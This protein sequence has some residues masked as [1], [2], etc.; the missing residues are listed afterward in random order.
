M[1]AYPLPGKLILTAYMHRF[2][3]GNLM[4]MAAFD[5]KSR[6]IKPIIKWHLPRENQQKRLNTDQ[7]ATTTEENQL[8]IVKWQQF[9]SSKML[10]G[11]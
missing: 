8:V 7:A 1:H 9:I 5:S 2:S 6:S 10:L 4:S 11:V 3:P